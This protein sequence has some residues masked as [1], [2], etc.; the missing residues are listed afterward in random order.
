MDRL[1]PGTGDALL[2]VDVQNDFLPGGSLAVPHGDEVIP[3]LNHCLALFG[4]RKLPV[5]ASRDWHPVD[6]CSFRAR[7][8]PWPPHC[9]ANTDGAMF[10]QNLRL[11]RDVV[12]IS[13]ADTAD[14]D[15]YSAFGST[16]LALCLKAA[17]VRR[18][19][20]G[21]LATDYC[22][23]NTVK[24]AVALGYPVVLLTD[25]VRAVEVSPGDGDRALDEMRKLGARLAASRE[26]SP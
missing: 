11:P 10:A 7:G 17:A 8:G 3:P 24:D 4:A 21:G 15:A 2:V 12:V 16:D 26:L 1:Q 25:A 19:F 13:K 14:K 9:M 23:L 6:H 5:Y 18:L 22:V 20:V